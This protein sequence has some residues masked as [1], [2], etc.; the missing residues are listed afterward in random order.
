LT[1]RKIVNM[2]EGPEKNVLLYTFFA[3]HIDI[4][5]EEAKGWLLTSPDLKRKALEQKEVLGW[6][7]SLVGFADLEDFTTA[8]F[9]VSFADE[10]VAWILSVPAS[11]IRWSAFLMQL[12]GKVR[13][14]ETFFSGP[15]TI[16]A[17]PD[18]P[19]AYVKIPIHPEWVLRTTY[20]GR[21]LL[22]G[23][24]SA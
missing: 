1:G 13:F 7:L 8:R 6:D 14:A 11:E 5:K 12:G 2:D 24:A 15:E 16:R 4:T 18:I 21:D 19:C 22:A 10:M 3:P 20:P 9:D 17:L 23:R